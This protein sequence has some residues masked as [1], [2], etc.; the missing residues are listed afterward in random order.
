MAV[1]WILL[2]VFYSGPGAGNA[3]AE[4]NNFEACQEAIRKIEILMTPT[5]HSKAICV[6]KG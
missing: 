1:K 2:W 5:R 4:F 3:T 6:Y